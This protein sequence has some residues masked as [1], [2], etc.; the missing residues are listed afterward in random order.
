MLFYSSQAPMMQMSTWAMQFL[1][2]QYLIVDDIGF[3]AYPPFEGRPGAFK[4]SLGGTWVVIGDTEHPEETLMFLDY[5][6]SDEALPLWIEANLLPVLKGVNYDDFDLAP[7]YRDFTNIVSNW[8][9]PVGYHIDILTPAHFT[10]VMWEGLPEVAAG[11]RTA[12][13]HANNMQ[14]EMDKAIEE[15]TNFD[16]TG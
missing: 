10:T 16:I 4:M 3:M 5:L 11:R 9:G 15:G 12:Q 1:T 8:D 14:A 2:F 7:V 13:E 6:V